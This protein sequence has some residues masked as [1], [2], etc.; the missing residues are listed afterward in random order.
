[1]KSIKLLKVKLVPFALLI[2]LA[3][4]T[5]SCTDNQNSKDAT[6]TDGVNSMGDTTTGNDHNMREDNNANGQNRMM[7]DS[8]ASINDVTATSDN[9]S[10]AAFLRKVAEINMEEI[11]LGKLAQQKGTMGHVKEL[12]KMMVA[13]HTLA[14]KDLSTLAKS[15]TTSLPTAESEKITDAYNKLKAKTGKNFDKEYSE[16]MVNG[17]KEAISIFER[18]NS[19]TKDADIK[20]M[21]TAMIP[22]LKNHLEHAEMC[23][24]ECDKM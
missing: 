5:W 4:A 13:E 11:K 18:T 19:D 12:G 14:M 9:N 8:N 15:K 24:K 21:T 17:H 23:K 2:G 20:A 22:K 7:H 1:M 10:D 6:T 3:T 16:M